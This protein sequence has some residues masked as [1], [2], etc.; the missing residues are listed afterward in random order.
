MFTGHKSDCA[1]HNGP[2]SRPMPCDCRGSINDY[3]SVLRLRNAA[4]LLRA[5]ALWLYE[6]YVIPAA[7]AL[8]RDI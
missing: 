7:F 4:Q 1:L 3:N 2:A 6:T 5:Y 8:R